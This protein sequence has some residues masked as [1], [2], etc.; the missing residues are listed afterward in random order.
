MEIADIKDIYAS[1]APKPLLLVEFS[2]SGNYVM[3][4]D[5]L[6]KEIEITKVLYQKSGHNTNLIIKK[7]TDK[8]EII[9]LLIKQIEK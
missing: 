5:R 7:N 9:S 4:Y 6:Q 2:A 3:E 8:S 1:P